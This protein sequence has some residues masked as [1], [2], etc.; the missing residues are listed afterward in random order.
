MKKCAIALLLVASLLIGTV[1]ADTLIV[2]TNA[3]GFLQYD[4]DGS[5]E[6]MRDAPGQDL[7]TGNNYNIIYTAATST[8][9]VINY[10]RRAPFNFN[11]SLL[12]DTATITDAKF[13]V[14]GFDKT[15][16]LGTFDA[17]LIYFSPA[18]ETSFVAGD[19]DNT[20]F[21]R[22]A[23][24]IPYASFNTGGMN[25]FTL[26]DLSVISKT[27]TT[28]LLFTHSADADDSALTWADGVYSGFYLG[29]MLTYPAFLTI[30]YTDAGGD[31]PVASFSCDHTFLRIPQPVTCTDTSTESPTSWNWSFGDGTYSEDENP[32][33]KY[34][35]RGSFNITLTATN[36]DGSDTSDITQEKVTGYE[37][38][39]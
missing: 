38:Y 5:W 18:S 29:G 1:N 33:H 22:V 36:G 32:V 35:R 7:S 39:T 4:I 31:P 15:N 28:H 6:S 13:T 23:N 30:E 34:T 19:Y 8:T 12:P 3:D 20:N 14:Y 37:T 16:G 17:S 10:H 25:N 24:D 2:D 26:T 11:T 27:G 21:T 9:D